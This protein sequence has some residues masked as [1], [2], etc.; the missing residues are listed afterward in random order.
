MLDG[1]I[2]K[3][4]EIGDVEGMLFLCKHLSSGISSEKDLR[5]LRLHNI[6]RISVNIDPALR[7][8]GILKQEFPQQIAA[9]L[10]NATSNSL[11]DFKSLFSAIFINYLISNA[12]VR[13][14]AIKF[15]EEFNTFYIPQNGFKLC[16]ACYRNLLMSFGIIDSR[17]KGGYFYRGDTEIIAKKASESRLKMTLA[18]LEKSLLSQ[19]DEGEQGEQFVLK[20]EY[21]RLA[22]HP[23]RDMIKQI[24]QIDVSAGYDIISFMSTYSGSLDRF[25]EVKTY[26]GNP[27][28]YW[29][30]NEKNTASIKGNSYYLYLVDIE[31][32]EKSGYV[33]TIIPNPV[34]FFTNNIDWKSS[35][36]TLYVERR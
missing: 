11:S 5:E 23:H 20:Y 26:R 33:P 7:L 18:Q 29:S 25:I 17:S 13:L 19:K 12:V 16:H 21:S 1:K 2:E 22:S 10:T 30:S 28:F 15:D 27:H 32:I 6:G 3:Y 8:I 36:E 34:S 9:L 24:S 35:V 14:E 4:S 31:S